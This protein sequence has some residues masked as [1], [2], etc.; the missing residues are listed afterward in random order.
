MVSNSFIFIGSP[1]KALE[2]VGFKQSFKNLFY[3]Y[4]YD[5]TFRIWLS[6]MP[7]VTKRFRK[8]YVDLLGPVLALLFLTAIVNYGYYLK[9]SNFSITPTPAI[10]YYAITMPLL[11][12]VLSKLSQSCITLLNSFVLLGYALY[13]HIFTLLISF[14]C[15]H[16]KSNTFFFICLVVFGGL[17]TLRV[18]LIILSTIQ[19]PAA[20]LIVCS[21]VSIVNLLFVIFLHFVYM[22]STFQYRTKV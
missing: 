22:H 14:V 13:G 5:L 18:A 21:I 19:V 11:C 17:S 8:M 3:V 1:Q 4:P 16:E 15:F 6:L 2:N 12:Y 10:M 7:P 9:K 20:R